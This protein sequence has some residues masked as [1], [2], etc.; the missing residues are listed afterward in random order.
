M[1]ELFILIFKRDMISQWCGIMFPGLTNMPWPTW[2]QSAKQLLANIL[3]KLPGNQLY[4]VL[5]GT[6]I[7][8]QHTSNEGIKS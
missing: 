1:S 6:E 8:N 4:K 2:K 5:C 7:L 3:P